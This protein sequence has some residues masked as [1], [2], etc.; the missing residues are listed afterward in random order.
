MRKYDIAVI[1]ASTTGSW[2]AKR[3]AENGF[4]VLMIE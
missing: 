1:G 2:F 3:M 4:R